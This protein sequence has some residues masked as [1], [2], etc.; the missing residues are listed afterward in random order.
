MRCRSSPGWGFGGKVGSTR[1]EIGIRPAR[2]N[3]ELGLRLRLR[4]FVKSPAVGV[5]LSLDLR[6]ARSGKCL[7]LNRPTLGV[8]SMSDIFC[9]FFQSR[10][11]LVDLLRRFL[12]WW[13]STLIILVFKASTLQLILVVR[14]LRKAVWDWR[15]L[16][17]WSGCWLSESMR[18]LMH[19]LLVL[20]RIVFLNR[21]GRF[22]KTGIVSVW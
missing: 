3:L 1:E 16:M 4:L 12:I 9:V 13:C 17:V 22:R 6:C 5:W 15:W 7:I 14:C 19:L 11:L 18:I 21:Y 20:A 2:R 8:K 10:I